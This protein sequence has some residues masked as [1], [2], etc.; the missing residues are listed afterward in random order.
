MKKPLSTK[1]RRATLK[2]LIPISLIWADLM[3]RNELQLGADSQVGGELTMEQ[4]TQAV[5]QVNLYVR[6]K[7][8]ELG[9]SQKEW[10]KLV[11]DTKEEMGATS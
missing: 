6:N 1:E 11:R 5:N 9:M 2:A 7:Y 10:N 3:D 8:I 4:Y